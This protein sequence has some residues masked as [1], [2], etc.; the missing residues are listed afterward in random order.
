MLAIDEPYSFYLAA[1]NRERNNPESRQFTPRLREYF[2]IAALIPYF[3]ELGVFRIVVFE[4]AEETSFEAFRTR[5]GRSEHHVNLVKVP[6]V[7]RFDP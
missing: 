5:Y 3:D 6:V 4:S 2:H 1:V 7:T